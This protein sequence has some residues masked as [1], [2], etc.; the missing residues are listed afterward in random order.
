MLGVD[1]S[2][3]AEER[4]QQRNIVKFVVNIGILMTRENS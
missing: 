4:V 3:V 1:R 2:Q